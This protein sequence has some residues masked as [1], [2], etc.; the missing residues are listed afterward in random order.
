MTLWKR[1]QPTVADKQ[2]L[3]HRLHQVLGVV[4]H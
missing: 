3:A 2:L 4:V 1:A